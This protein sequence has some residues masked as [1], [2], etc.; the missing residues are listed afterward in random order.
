[1][2]WPRLT[3]YREPS[4]STPPDGR[5]ILRAVV[6][7]QA[8]TASG[9][10]DS[11]GP[12]LEA[13]LARKP[14]DSRLLT[15]AAARSD[16]RGD[17]EGAESAL[18]R[19]LEHAADSDRREV[20]TRLGFLYQNLDRFAE[21]ADRFAEVVGGMPSHPAAVPLLY[22]LAN[23]QRLREALEWAR[24]IREAHPEVPRQALEVEANILDYV[25]DI[26]AAILC[27]DE[28][29]SRLDGTPVDQVNL[30]AAQFRGGEHAAAIAT[31]HTIDTSELWGEPLS[32]LKL[33]QLKL[34]LG[35]EGYLEDAY[36]ARIHRR[37]ARERLRLGAPQ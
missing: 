10:D 26:S 6:L 20:L 23:S 27:L 5:D 25:G 34:L 14:D 35:E 24:V 3:C 16:Y 7:T 9:N 8:E 2:R 28:L 37:S 4:R 22:C 33:A 36:L 32:I 12:I 1:M 29:C 13:A 21:A 31:V 15:L 17:P 11:V 18:L 19:A 30:A